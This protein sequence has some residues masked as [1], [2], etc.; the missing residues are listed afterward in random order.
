MIRDQKASNPSK[1][2][3]MWYCPGANHA[4]HHAPQE[5][6][7][8]YKG[9]FDD[10]YDAYRKW[11]LPRMVAKGV[12]PKG[13]ELT[14]FNPLPEN[15][16]NPADHVRPW[17]SLNAD[18]KKLFSRLAEVFAG[19][20]EYTDVQIG[21]IIDYLEKT[22]QLDNTIVLYAADNGASGEGTPN[23]SV[24]ENKFFN[25]YPDDLAE[26]M[27][28]LDVLGGPDTYEHYPTGWAAAFS[29]PFKMFKRYS[30]YAGGTCDPFVVSWPKGIKAR[31]EVRNQYH[32]A[33]DIV[34]TILDICGL[35][36]PEVYKGV[37]QYPLSGV[38]MRYTFTAAPDAPTQKKRQYYA[39]LGTRALWEDGWK[40][41]ALHAPFTG[42]GHFDQDQWELYHVDAD[43]SESK[44]LAK[45]YPEKF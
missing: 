38:S 25:G 21:R 8:K 19:F 22:G 14:P 26:N 33:V 17:E 31:G 13:T 39:M 24:N 10:G 32:H 36:M 30:E 45:E 16:A 23:G 41:V 1:P 27:K 40:V 37:R 29:A 18:E 34:P 2:W 43:R 3:F 5:Y 35:K 42:K 11:V 28:Y 6:I 12:I 20:S 7:D 4:P 15:V 44:D 9:K